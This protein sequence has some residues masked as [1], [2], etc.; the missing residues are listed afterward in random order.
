MTW[1]TRRILLTLT[2]MVAATGVA[3]GQTPSVVTV[4]GH[5]DAATDRQAIQD[6]VDAAGVGGVVEL[7]G[8]FQLDG[9]AVRIGVDGLELRGALVDSDG[10]GRFH[11]DWP[12]GRDN[13]GDGLVDEDDW[14]AVIHGVTDSDG[15]AVLIDAGNILY[16]RGFVVDGAFPPVSDLVVHD[17]SFEGF[18]RAIEM[19]PEWA[20]ASGRC[21]DRV[22][23]AGSVSHLRVE[24]NRFSNGRLGVVLL[25]GV[26]DVT[27]EGN[28]FEDL[29]TFGADAEGGV[30]DC[31]LPAGGEVLL[32][33]TPPR[34]VTMAGN[35]SVRGTLSVD[36]TEGAQIVDNTFEGATLGVIALGG[37]HLR[38]SGNRS[39]GT[40][41]PIV[42]VDA[43]DSS[44]VGNTL[45]AAL[46][47]ID[48][49]G[50][51]ERTRVV[52]NRI[53]A[54]FVG[55]YVEADSSGYRVLENTYLDGPFVDVV[56][57]SGSHENFLVNGG[58]PISLLDLGSGNRVE[59]NVVPF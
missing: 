2:L 5:D 6:A 50:T 40:L 37:S 13:D 27:I 4:V 10:D 30:H 46:I 20:S 26:S 43:E 22:H 41:V 12:D 9:D 28:V 1:R 19:W 18:N 31:P 44:I 57:D 21:D 16:N 52:D 47:G 56:F 54:S 36:D 8:T 51:A 32:E 15:E 24:G 7:V 29:R 39:T 11:E 42:T 48:L 38:I 53:E 17:L 49:E 3:L 23:V 35:L 55:V 58:A 45:M 25:G 59:G 14:D 33:L 34:R